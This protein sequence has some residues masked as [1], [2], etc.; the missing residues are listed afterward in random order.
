MSDP[1]DDPTQVLF[2]LDH[3]GTPQNFTAEESVVGFLLAERPSPASRLELCEKVDT[4]N[5]LIQ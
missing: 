1:F 4:E 5:V 2:E 3:K